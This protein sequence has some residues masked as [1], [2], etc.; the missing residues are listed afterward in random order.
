MAVV[1]VGSQ[2]RRVSRQVRRG[3]AWSFSPGD[4]ELSRNLPPLSSEKVFT[5]FL[6]TMF[7]KEWVVHAKPPF[8]GTST[9]AAVSGPLRAP[10]SDQ[11]VRSNST[12]IPPDRCITFI[13]I[14]TEWVV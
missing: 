14:I 10:G 7:R 1:T 4:A 8:G 3:F 6:R 11:P 13:S 2:G 9:C 12:K 5:T